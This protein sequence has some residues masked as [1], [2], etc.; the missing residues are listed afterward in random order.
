AH[1][2]LLRPYENSFG[3]GERD[4]EVFVLDHLFLTIN[5]VVDSITYSKM[6]LYAALAFHKSFGYNSVRYSKCKKF[7]SGR[8]ALPSQDRILSGGW[9][10]QARSFTAHDFSYR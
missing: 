10:S 4:I 8:E 7:G 6:F 3:R 9:L 5:D 2:E 1:A